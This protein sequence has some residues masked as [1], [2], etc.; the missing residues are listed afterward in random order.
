MITVVTGLPR[1]G[2][3]LTMQMLVAGGLPALVDK[4]PDGKDKV[5]TDELNPRGYV[6]YDDVKLLVD[7]PGLILQAE[8]G[9]VKIVSE[10]LFG[11]PTVV[12]VPWGQNGEDTPPIDMGGKKMSLIAPDYKVVMTER[13]IHEV[14]DSQLQW[15]H[16]RWRWYMHA[17]ADAADRHKVELLLVSHMEQCRWFLKGRHIPTFVAQYAH[18]LRDPLRVACDLA[19]FLELPLN[20]T[21]MAG[22]VH[23]ELW[24][25]RK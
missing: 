1:S 8:G 5:V 20:T 16:R 6:E 15:I 21:A 14:M 10:W 24:R 11:L 22:A 2:T 7:K 13:N 18:V 4:G 12:P 25:N 19:A 17:W 9:C 3:S 23:P